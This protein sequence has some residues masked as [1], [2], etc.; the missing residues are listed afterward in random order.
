[1]QL[2]RNKWIEPGAGVEGGVP[3]GGIKRLCFVLTGFT[4]KLFIANLYFLVFSIPIV[5][6]PAA[7][8]ALTYI[9]MKLARD[10]VCYVWEEFWKEFKSRFLS[11]LGCALLV[12]LLPV[13]LYL[14]CRLLGGSN[15]SMGIF[16]VAAIF[17]FLLKSYWFASMSVIDLPPL[18]NLKN[19]MMLMFLE[20][21][22]TLLMAVSAGTLMILLIVCL[23][24]SMFV[25][26]ILI[27]A[28]IQ[29]IVSVI[30]NPAIERYLVKD[31]GGVKNSGH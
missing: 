4:G 21:K 12:D 25:F 22:R 15:M 8:S 11:K 18:V 6:I 10:G 20:W 31:E 14:Y 5:T 7:K 3:G 16:I 26:P 24:Y 27:F 13:S 1:M 30:T 19:A 28:V 2:F 29:L 23:P 17:A 9:T